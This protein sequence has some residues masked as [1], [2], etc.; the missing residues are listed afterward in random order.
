MLKIFK[1]KRKEVISIEVLAGL[2]VGCV[3]CVN[4]CRR[5]VLSMGAMAGYPVATVT[6]PEYCVGCGKC[7][8]VCPADAIELITL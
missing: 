4:R 8:S 6:S 1:R 3:R 7:V 5:N 2:C